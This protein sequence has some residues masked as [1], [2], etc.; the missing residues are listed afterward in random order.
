MDNQ[1]DTTSQKM[2]SADEIERVYPVLILQSADVTKY[3]W[4]NKKRFWKSGWR[5]RTDTN[6]FGKGLQ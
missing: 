2:I 3:L 1:T 6:E 5:E 4:A